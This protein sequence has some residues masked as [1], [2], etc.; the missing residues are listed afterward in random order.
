M[1]YVHDGA[2]MEDFL[3]C[4]DLKRTTKAKDIFKCVNFF[5]AKHDLDIQIIGSVCTDGAP[6]MLGNKSFFFLLC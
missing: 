1:R 2:I 6:A 4:E 3:F 5:F